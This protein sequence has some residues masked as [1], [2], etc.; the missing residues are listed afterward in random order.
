MAVTTPYRGIRLL[1]RAGQGLLNSEVHLEQ[2]MCKVLG[3]EMSIGTVEIARDDITVGG[4]TIAELIHN[5]AVV[6]D[7][8]HRSNLKVSPNK[9]RILLPDVEVYGIR[10]SNGFVQPSPHRVTDLGKINMTDIKTVR[11]LNSWRGLYKTLIGHLPHLSYYMEPFDKFSSSRKPADT[12]EWTQELSLAFKNAMAHL[13]EIN[14]TF[15]PKPTD[16]LILKPDAAKTNTCIGWVLYALRH[17]NGKDQLLPVM[18]CSAR[19]PEYMSRWYPCEI[20]AVGAVLDIDQVAH[21]I[22]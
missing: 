15:L 4:N 14:K 6:L 21:W 18:Y 8:L 13:D 10:V 5:W 20:E 9:V 17:V 19:L 2:M 22:N 11:Q 3:D 16:R 1:T 7:K 12:V